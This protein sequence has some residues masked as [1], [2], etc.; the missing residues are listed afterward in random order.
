MFVHWLGVGGI[1]FTILDEDIQWRYLKDY[2]SKYP[3]SKITVFNRN[4][5]DLFERVVKLECNQRYN[6]LDMDCNSGFTHSIRRFDYKPKN[7]EPC[8]V[9]ADYFFN[10]VVE[11]S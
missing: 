2:L 3:D 7:I 1:R 4:S 5:G 10:R 11:A 9:Q 8:G 6:D